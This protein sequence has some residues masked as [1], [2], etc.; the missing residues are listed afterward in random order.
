MA[1][2][3][4]K[5]PSEGDERPKRVCKKCSKVQFR[6]R[7]KG[8]YY[9]W[10]PKV[11]VCPVPDGIHAPSELETALEEKSAVESDVDSAEDMDFAIIRQKRMRVRRRQG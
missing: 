11:G 7:I 1:H 10:R 3:W 8:R 4:E 2:K 5:F 6:E 9:G